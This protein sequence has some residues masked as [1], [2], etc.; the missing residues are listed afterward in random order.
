MGR[1][2]GEIVMPEQAAQQGQSAAQGGAR[3]PG[4]PGIPKGRASSKST[5]IGIGVVGTLLTAAA[6]AGAI[7]MLGSASSPVATQVAAVS[8]PAIV[9]QAPAVAPVYVPA[10]VQPVPTVAPV[11]DVAPAPDL[12]APGQCQVGQRQQ[13]AITLYATQPN[14]LGNVLRVHSGSYVS[15]P[16]VLTR[17]QQIVRFPAPPGATNSARIILEKSNSN[18]GSTFDDVDGVTS[19]Y[20]GEIDSLHYSVQLRWTTP[21]C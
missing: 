9:A 19:E 8:A 14:E 10:P 18:L 6:I 5:I 11:P 4:G 1:N 7:M 17:T 20:A 16:I 2:W 3:P 12:N 15:P 21:R 13:L